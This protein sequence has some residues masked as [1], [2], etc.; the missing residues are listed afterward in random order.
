MARSSTPAVTGQEAFT[1]GRPQELE[2]NWLGHVV[3]YPLPGGTVQ[4]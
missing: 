3:D 2:Q 1:R 4:C